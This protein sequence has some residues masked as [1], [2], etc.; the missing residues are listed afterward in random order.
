MRDSQRNMKMELNQDSMAEDP[1]KQTHS[2]PKIE[3]GKNGSQKDSINMDAAAQ[4]GA[5][6]AGEE[7]FQPGMQESS[8]GQNTIAQQSQEKD[9]NLLQPVPGPAGES[10]ENQAANSMQQRESNMPEEQS[11]ISGIP[12]RYNHEN[13]IPKT[14][15]QNDQQ[16]Q[17][18]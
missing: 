14:I 5:G 12:A 3:E 11:F 15:E 9:A 17:H 2:Q 13:T 6:N 7:G 1:S 16:H 10:P 18:P 8:L 4:D